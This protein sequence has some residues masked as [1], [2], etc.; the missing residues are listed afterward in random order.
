LPEKP[1][2]VKYVFLGYNEE[3]FQQTDNKYMY[4]EIDRLEI[5]PR[6]I[7]WVGTEMVNES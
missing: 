4:F 3:K 5:L 2:W 6:H 1:F 7:L